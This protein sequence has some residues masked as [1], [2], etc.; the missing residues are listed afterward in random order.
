MQS[1]VIGKV[2]KARR[3]AQEKDRVTFTSFTAGFKGD[4]DDYLVEYSAENMVCSCPFFAG[5]GFCSHSMALHRMLEGMLPSARTPHALASIP[6]ETATVS[7]GD[8]TEA[9]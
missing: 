1:S 5:H 2:E 7:L 9:V 6:L 3:Y 4:N 8:R